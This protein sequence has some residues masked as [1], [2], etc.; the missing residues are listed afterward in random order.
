M[1]VSVS[2]QFTGAFLKTR[3]ANKFFADEG[4]IYPLGNILAFRSGVSFV[5][6]QTTYVAED[7]INFCIE[8]PG[9]DRFTS[10]AIHKLF[11]SSLG[12]ILGSETYINCPIEIESNKILIN[13]MFQSNGITLTQGKV[14]FSASSLVNG[15]G[16][17]YT[18][19]NIKAGKNAPATAYSTLMGDKKCI[20]FMSES[21]NMFYS[22]MNE[23]F[24]ESV[25]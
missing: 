9:R 5:M 17:L 8:L 1:I 3:F 22:T 10:S 15:A 24:L 19:I 2:D 16:L 7:A 12:S 21:I 25:K 20:E 6:D 13:K 11:N 23:L 18:G 14:S 4:K